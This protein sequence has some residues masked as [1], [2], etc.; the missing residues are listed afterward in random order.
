MVDK[1]VGEIVDLFRCVECGA[2]D[3]SIEKD[4]P[5]N[6]TAYNFRSGGEC[7]VCNKCY[8]QFPITHDG[9]PMMWTAQIKQ[10]FNINKNL[11]H[12]NNK[13]LSA[14]FAN[15]SH[16]DR[17]SD[18]YSVAF[19]RNTHLAKKI[20]TG[21]KK[22]MIMSEDLKSLTNDKL[23][24]LDIGC[25]PGH[26]IEW[27]NANFK[28]QIGLD[29]SLINLRNTHKNTGA[30]VVLGDATVMPFKADTFN[31]VTG[32][33]VLHHIFDWEKAIMESC[34]ICSKNGGILFDSEPTAESLSLSAFA[35]L[36]FELR[37]PVYKILSYFDPKK[38]HFRDISAAKDYYKTAEVHN[39]PG[40]GFSVK[41]VQ[42]VFSSANFMTEV[43]LSP[44]E[45]LQKRKKIPKNE[46]GWKR[47]L[48]HS[49]SGHNPFL[50]KYGSFTL[51]GIP[52]KKTLRVK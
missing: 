38:M 35:K 32:A 48:L 20:R 17:I 52:Q 23:Y 42:E 14:V 36:V 37:W 18:N 41:R 51:L 3:L 6:W 45:D 7:L 22:L 8:S 19:R 2:P 9:I 28:K 27:L 25:G 40:K 44:N 4:D 13:N 24:H 10:I 39:Q 5:S 21:A 47:I 50:S 31:L 26:V 46:A 49:L 11:E 30:H 34:R 16:Y 1:N 12:Q 43:F 33:A 15:M 29:V